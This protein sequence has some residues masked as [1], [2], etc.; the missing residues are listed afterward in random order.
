MVRIR[1]VEVTRARRASKQPAEDAQP[2]HAPAD[3]PRGIYGP[4]GQPR[5]FQDPAMDRFVAVVLK[6][7]QELWV[8]TERVDTLERLSAAKRPFLKKHLDAMLDDPRVVAER[9]AKMSDFVN[10]VLDPLRTP[11]TIQVN[12]VTPERLRILA[13]CLFAWM[14]TNMDQSL[15]G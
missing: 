6:L 12:T 10:R 4:D 15:F 2:T 5:F 3:A 11:W 9:D 8:M 7:T 1:R 14:V 13:I